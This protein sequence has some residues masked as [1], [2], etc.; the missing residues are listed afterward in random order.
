MMSRAVLEQQSQAAAF[1]ALLERRFSCRGYLPGSVPMHIIE[2][3]LQMAQRTP[4]WCNSQPWQ[5]HITQPAA[6]E[7]LRKRLAAS[8]LEDVQ[9]DI[10]PPSEY[11]GV[12]RERRRACGWQLYDSVG[13]KEGDRQASARQGAENF[14]FFGAPHVGVSSFSVQ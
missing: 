7:R 11:L 3:L 1:D 5:V 12:Y 4:S 13:V 10:S 8:D 6:T 2:T 14:R 9:W